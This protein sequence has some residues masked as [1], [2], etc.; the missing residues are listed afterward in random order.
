M[1]DVFAHAQLEKAGMRD[2]WNYEGHREPFQIE[3][4]PTLYPEASQRGKDSDNALRPRET[5]PKTLVGRSTSLT[6]HI[7]PI[8]YL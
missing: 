1:I 5:C 8:L 3:R 6:T 2:K 4:V 7:C